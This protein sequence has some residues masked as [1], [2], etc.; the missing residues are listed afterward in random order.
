MK[1]AVRFRVPTEAVRDGIND[2]NV[3]QKTGPAQKLGWVE[4]EF[5]PE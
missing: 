4:M 3:I 5:Q 1:R 2:V